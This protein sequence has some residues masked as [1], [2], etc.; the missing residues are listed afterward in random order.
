MR[1]V[2]AEPVS[3]KVTSVEISDGAYT[4]A[5]HQRAV[6]RIFQSVVIIEFLK[7]WEGVITIAAST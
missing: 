3:G 5:L 4:S 2:R 7:I 6:V 1:D